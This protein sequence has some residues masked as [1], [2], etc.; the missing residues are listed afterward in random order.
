M[1]KE[2]HPQL[3]DVIFVDTSCGAEFVTKST[4]TSEQT[5]DV[6]GVAFYVINVEVSSASHPFYTGKQRFVDSARRIEKFQEREKKVEKAK[7]AHKTSKKAK[8][9]AKDS[10]KVAKAAL[11]D[12]LKDN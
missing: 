9:K 11:K 4:I 10:K 3:N 2:L 1:K 7:E 12:A 8:R 5:R 6:D